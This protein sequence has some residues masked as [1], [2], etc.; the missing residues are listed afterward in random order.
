[1]YVIILCIHC[2][3][4]YMIMI[5]TYI[6]VNRFPRCFSDSINITTDVPRLSISTRRC[7]AL[8]SGLTG[9]DQLSIWTERG[10]VIWFVTA[11]FPFASLKA[12]DASGPPT[13]GHRSPRFLFT[14]LWVCWQTSLALRC[15][16]SCCGQRKMRTSS[17]PATGWCILSSPP[18]PH[19]WLWRTSLLYHC[20]GML[21]GGLGR[22]EK[23]TKIADPI[24]FWSTLLPLY[25]SWTMLALLTSCYA[26]QAEQGGITSA[27][28]SVFNVMCFESA[29][30]IS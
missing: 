23:V 27:Y 19:T 11:V 1:M 30:K 21:S 20:D 13:K 28:W 10:R 12:P 25:T 15:P 29:L 16:P 24:S 8:G 2:E 5:T 7:S 14:D 4:K 26:L 22:R 17:L 6:Q 18:P 9:P 3:V